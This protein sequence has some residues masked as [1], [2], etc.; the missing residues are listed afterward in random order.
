[1]TGLTSGTEF[2]ESWGG[3][4]TPPRVDEVALAFPGLE[5][6]GFIGAGGMGFVHHVRERPTGREAALKLL[7][8]ALAADPAFVERFNREGATLARLDHPN[9]VKV[10]AY[11]TTGG[12]CHLLMEFVDGA[13]LRQALRA[14]R[15]T[16]AQALVIAPQLCE[17]LQYA[18][19]QGVLHRDIKPE[20]ILLDAEGRV[21]IA[22]FGIA[23]LLDATPGTG[24]DITLTQ[25]GQRL[26]TPHYMAPEQIERPNDVDHRADI[27][28]LGVV[29]YELLTGE[30]PL[31]RFP[32]PS[33]KA[34]VDQRIDDVV[35]RALAKER[36]LRQ[37]SATE[38]RSQ[39]EEASS[40]TEDRKESET[41]LRSDRAYVSTPKHLGSLAALAYIY[42]GKGRL[43]LTSDALI[44]ESGSGREVI[45]FRSVRGLG[46]G[47]YPRLAK[48]FGLNYLAVECEGS[49]GRRTRLFTP[50]RSGWDPVGVTNELVAEWRKL[51][52]DRVA[53]VQGAPPPGID[54]EALKVSKPGARLLVAADAAGF[55]LYLLGALA[56]LV[57]AAA[58]FAHAGPRPGNPILQAT[59]LA[60]I[61]CAPWAFR[62]L[63][64]RFPRS[65]RGIA[66]WV[67]MIVVIA[68]MV[69]V[70]ELFL[71]TSRLQNDPPAVPQ[72][73]STIDA[74]TLKEAEAADKFVVQHVYGVRAPNG[75]KA[76][77]AWDFRAPALSQIEIGHD[78]K[79]WPVENHRLGDT[80]NW[81]LLRVTATYVIS[82]ESKC[83]V[84]V[85]TPGDGPGLSFEVDR[86][87]DTDKFLTK[88]V[89]TEPYD[90]VH[91]GRIFGEFGRKTPFA[92]GGDAPIEVRIK[93][94]MPAEG[95]NGVTL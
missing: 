13:N 31:G 62:F 59:N 84:E 49:G 28:S 81:R 80:R 79:W 14:G 3:R 94:L 20:N 91:L 36:E 53:A 22:D 38:V 61:L 47:E 41:V 51:V 87:D 23:K 16:P 90:G 88:A 35:F 21:K 1:M 73:S 66:R 46:I 67:G 24:P 70:Q 52:A 4:L 72:T 2:G 11:G 34:Y 95:R 45:P 68:A 71:L 57:L 33:A 82:G 26:G 74:D 29:I 69:A 25:T 50:N 18:H 30:L 44:Y 5:I 77:V 6:L 19:A 9:I 56:A 89:S 75:Q 40:P 48:P 63:M 78:E 93:R 8:P 65:D 42:T 17:A 85:K 54:P 7:P 32:A 39:L 83:T 12:F 43:R 15:F 76:E 86:I 92:F 58:R 55:G 64:Q 27:Y 37:Q 60:L 10:F